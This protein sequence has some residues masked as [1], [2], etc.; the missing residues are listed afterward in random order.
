MEITEGMLALV[1]DRLAPDGADLSRHYVRAARALAETE[2]AAHVV[3]EVD[4]FDDA[5]VASL[6]R[7]G[8]ASYTAMEAAETFWALAVRLRSRCT[9]QHAAE[10][11]APLQALLRDLAQ[12][13]PDGTPGQAD[14]ASAARSLVLAAIVVDLAADDPVALRGMDFADTATRH[15][16]EQAVVTLLRLAVAFQDGAGPR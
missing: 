10:A 8:D 9:G 5:Q 12:A 7:S 11:A 16:V 13:A 6:M 2:F 3:G 1:G 15:L 4:G 14:F